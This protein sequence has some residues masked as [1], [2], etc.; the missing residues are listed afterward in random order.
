MMLGTIFSIFSRYRLD[1][2]LDHSEELLFFVLLGQINWARG[3]DNNLLNTNV[4]IG[5]R[6]MELISR[7]STKQIHRARN[8]LSQKGIISFSCGTGK[9]NYARYRLGPYFDDFKEEVKTAKLDI[10]TKVNDIVNVQVYDKENDQLNVQLNDQLNVQLTARKRVRKMSNDKHRYIEHRDTELRTENL[11]LREENV[12]SSDRTYVPAD[13]E[14]SAPRPES[15]PYE[16]IATQFMGICVDLP[17]IK[18]VKDW[19]SQRK[20]SVKSLWKKHNSL[21]WFIDLFMRVHDSDFLSGRVNSF[22]AGFDWIF[23][24]AN[25]QKILE[26]NYDNRDNSAQKFAGLKAFW[27]E[28]QAE[29]A[30]KDAA[31]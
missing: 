22:K 1:H 3:E 20:N 7:M 31:K 12:E 4:E 6:K 15:T 28:A 5:N 29:E 2:E 16:E 10:G 30:M 24:P 8:G 21:S 23:K 17:R 14:T 9:K 18:E 27:E 25:L 26:G 19:T 13:A 11:D